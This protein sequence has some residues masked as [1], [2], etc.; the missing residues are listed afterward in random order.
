M[1]NRMHDCNTDERF[2][3]RSNIDNSIMCKWYFILDICISVAFRYQ[4]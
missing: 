1:L 4:Y 3:N 2:T